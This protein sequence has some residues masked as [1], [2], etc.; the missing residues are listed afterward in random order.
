MAAD[1]AQHVA[2]VI[3][4]AL[5]AGRWV[6][7]DRYAA[8]TL[9]YQG[10]GRGLDRRRSSRR[11]VGWATGGLRPDLTVL[12]DLPVAVAAAR[13]RRRRRRP[14][15]VRGR[16][17][18]TSG[19]P[20]GSWP[21]R[22]DAATRGWWS[23]PPGRWTTVAASVWDAVEAL[24]GPGGPPG[25]PVSAPGGDP[26]PTRRCSSAVVGQERAVARLV[27][28][29]ASP[30]HA[31]LFHGPPGSAASG[32]PP[33]GLAAALLCPDGGCGVCN[34]CRRALAGTHPGPG[35][36]GA[37]RVRRS[38]STT[39]GRSPPGPSVA[40]WSRPARCCWCPTSTWR[41]KAAPALLKTVE[42][43]PPSTV[44]VLLADDLPPGLATIVS[45]CVQVPFAAVSP[46]R[47]SRRGWSAG[48]S[49]PRWPPRWPLRPA[50]T[51]TGPG[52]WP[53]I[54]GSTDRR[55]GG[56]RSRAGSTAPGRRR[57]RWPTSCSALA[58]GALAPLRERH[59]RELAALEEQAE[60][61]GARGVPGRRAV[62]DRHKR[63]ER[64]WRT[65]DLRMGLAA[66][67]DAY[68]DRLVA[69]VAGE[70]PAGTP[71]VGAERRAAAGHV[72]AVGRAAAAL[73]RNVRED[74]LLESLMVELSGMLE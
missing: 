64:R 20:T 21:W 59:A 19:W 53:T 22:P 74:L 8:S 1:R 57:C 62:E 65:D 27:A 47:W 41:C 40:R 68:R 72:E 25:A 16:R 38:T 29:P 36:R 37:D 7:T 2:E 24:A 18:S 33:A 61:T 52:C 10:Y 70:A 42:E 54:P 13:R 56:G 5:A 58:D 51:S 45:R 71:G 9:A 43:P 28:R 35:D 73:S 48:A 6:V 63:E 60:A 69:T 67:A 55:R 14:D 44:F 31:Y 23:T 66:L 4:P 3:E 11:L 12:L 15:G 30:V 49:P 34:S 39:P 46:R 26:V 17:R 32:P 50:G